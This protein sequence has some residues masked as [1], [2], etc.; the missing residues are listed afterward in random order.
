MSIEAISK[1]IKDAQGQIQI[2]DDQ[3][4]IAEEEGDDVEALASQ[5][6]ELKTSLEGLQ[7]EYNTELRQRHNMDLG[8]WIDEK[9]EE[10]QHITVSI[11]RLSNTWL[12]CMSYASICQACQFRWAS[13]VYFTEQARERMLLSPENTD[14]YDRFVTQE[15]RKEAIEKLW[16]AAEY[17]Y[18]EAAERL[19]DEE[20]NQEAPQLYRISH[21]RAL[22]NA[23]EFWENR[24]QASK[25]TRE[26][27][28]AMHNDID[29][30][31]RKLFLNA[32]PSVAIY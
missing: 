4:F 3:K 16:I 29:E 22:N 20:G 27:E 31:Q 11:D 12:E 15:E 2:L 32:L 14:A 6:E 9:V 5:L 7:N 30:N 13:A 10:A 28:A 19:G 23:R 25:Q 17:A 21:D 24:R 1:Q 26:K 18:H 8:K